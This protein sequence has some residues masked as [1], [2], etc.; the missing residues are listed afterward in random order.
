MKLKEVLKKFDMSGNSR[1]NQISV[2]QGWLILP[3]ISLIASIG[4]ALPFT[5]YEVLNSFFSK[6]KFASFLPLLTKSPLVFRNLLDL[7]ALYVL[8]LAFN[9]TALIFFL[10]RKKSTPIMM[11]AVYLLNLAD[12][13]VLFNT[14]KAENLLKS[15]D[16]AKYAQGFTFTFISSCIWCCYFLFSKR[17]KRTFT[18]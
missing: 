10:K 12:I 13:I 16:K 9:I 1:Q 3:F 6:I 18:K 15:F 17:V 4:F 11:I 7:M 8:S 5:I 14:S 2:F